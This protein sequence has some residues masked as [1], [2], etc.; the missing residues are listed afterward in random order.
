MRNWPVHDAKANFNELLKACIKD[1][2]QMVTRRGADAAVLVPVAE[3]QRLT[4][5][6]RA[7]L[8]DLL[9]VDRARGDLDLPERGQH[10][11]RPVE[12]AA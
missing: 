4:Q 11:R 3:W 1:G 12:P 5:A 10:R 8:K 9:L 7:S 2:P 6:P